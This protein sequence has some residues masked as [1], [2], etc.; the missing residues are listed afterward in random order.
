VQIQTGRRK[1]SRQTGKHIFESHA[2]LMDEEIQELVKST[3]FSREELLVLHERFEY[4]DRTGTDTLSFTDLQ[5]IPEFNSNPFRSLILNY[6]ETNYGNLGFYS[7]LD[8]LSILHKKTKKE[9]RILYLFSIMDLNR[10]GRLCRDVMSKLQTIMNNRQESSEIENLLLNYDE[11]SKGYLDLQDFIVFYNSYPSLED[12]MVI[13]FAT[14]IP[15][16]TPA[17]LRFLRMF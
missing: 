12:V 2:M 9:K 17:I 14:C 5:M 6:I 3:V 11:G 4:L 13:D 1:E 16:P 15:L 8:F 7:F 10:N